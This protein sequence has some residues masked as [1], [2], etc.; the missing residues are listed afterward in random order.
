M[1][2]ITR[3]YVQ[4]DLARSQVQEDVYL[5]GKKQILSQTSL[6]SRLTLPQKFKRAGL[7]DGKE[8]YRT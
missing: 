6:A 7:N 8:A 4:V 1:D 5:L 3:T 2:L